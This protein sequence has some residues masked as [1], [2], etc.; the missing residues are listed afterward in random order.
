MIYVPKSRV[1]NVHL[2][3]KWFTEIH[4]MSRLEFSFGRS[5]V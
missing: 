2:D 3:K 4:I 5:S 1:H